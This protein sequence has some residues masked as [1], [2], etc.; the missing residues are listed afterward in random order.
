MRIVLV[1]RPQEVMDDLDLDLLRTR[2]DGL[3]GWQAEVQDSRLS[4]A[5]YVIVVASP[6]SAEVD[7]AAVRELQQA[8]GDLPRMSVRLWQGVGD[9]ASLDRIDPTRLAEVAEETERRWQGR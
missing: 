2:I 8:F 3:A 9:E 7:T 1:V 6:R 4:D 5:P